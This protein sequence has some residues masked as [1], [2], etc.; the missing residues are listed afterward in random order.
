M[1][2]ELNILVQTIREALDDNAR[3]LAA[4]IGF[5]AFFSIF[6]L[7]IGIFSLAGY[8][9]ESAEVQ[10]RIGEVVSD[11]LPGSADLVRDNIKS[12]VKHRGAMG[13]IG[14]A[15]L[16]VTAGKG[17]GALTRAVNH[18]LGVKRNPNFL[19]SK[20]RQFLMAVAVS[21]LMILSMGATVAAEIFLDP[22]FLSRLGLPP[23]E[24]PRFE[25]WFLGFV[26]VLLVFALIYKMAPYVEVQWRQ[27][28]PGAIL[29]AVLFELCK[30]GFVLYL[31]RIANF[32]AIY[33]SLS[34]II[35]LLLWLYLSALILI[36]G[37][38][39]NIVRARTRSA[40]DSV[41]LKSVQ[42]EAGGIES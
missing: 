7:L 32:Q 5:W 14:I 17:F 23:F 2:R 9:L 38:E 20:L 41:A 30:S 34:S 22:A 28:V 37:A 33:G 18:A 29:A 3:D 13:W 15:G 1:K 27:V 40:D 8:T 24:V 12:V 39:Y 11:L 36:I 16:L 19:L 4:A 42:D 6:P 31:G 21:M 25:G 26:M 35:V 10:A